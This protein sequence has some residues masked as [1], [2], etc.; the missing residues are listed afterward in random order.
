MQ[1]IRQPNIVIGRGFCGE[2]HRMLGFRLV[3][4]I[5]VIIIIISLIIRIIVIIVIAVIAIFLV[6]QMKNGDCC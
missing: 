6:R 2:I 1:N 4:L 3:Q 5:S